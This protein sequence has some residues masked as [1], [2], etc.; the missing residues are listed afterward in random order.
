MKWISTHEGSPLAR[1]Q[2]HQTLDVPWLAS[3]VSAN[4][5]NSLALASSF[6]ARLGM[7][8]VGWGYVPLVLI[9]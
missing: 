3:C 1:I 8:L 9:Q 7:I 2:V 5:W 4:P 6:G